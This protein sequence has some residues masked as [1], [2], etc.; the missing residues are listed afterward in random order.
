MQAAFCI[1]NSV[2]GCILGKTGVP[3]LQNRQDQP[4]GFVPFISKIVIGKVE[5]A[6]VAC[7]KRIADSALNADTA[8]GQ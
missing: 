2:W 6:D 5:C 1:K 8:N 4:E 7:D 3:V